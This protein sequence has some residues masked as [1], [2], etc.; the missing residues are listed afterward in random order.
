MLNGTEPLND[1]LLSDSPKPLQEHAAYKRT[2]AARLL[3]GAA[4]GYEAIGGRRRLLS[5]SLFAI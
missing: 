2:K 4:F 1:I 5:I 3:G